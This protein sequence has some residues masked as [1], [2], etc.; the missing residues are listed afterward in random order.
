MYEAPPSYA[1]AVGGRH[2]QHG[3]YDAP[4]ESRAVAS[5]TDEPSSSG[6]SPPIL[7]QVPPSASAHEPPDSHM[8]LAICVCFCCCNW[9]CGP[10]A[11]FLSYI[12]QESADSGDYNR[13]HTYGKASFLL[14]VFTLSTALTVVLGFILYWFFSNVLNVLVL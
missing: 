8:L 12:S 6:S 4:V 2:E 10:I 9:I 1:E 3:K 5:N 13:A 11:I 7:F 14:S